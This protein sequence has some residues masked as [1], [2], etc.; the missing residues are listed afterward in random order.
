MAEL[1]ELGLRVTTNA[2]EA[3]AKLDRLDNSAEKAEQ[4]SER[5]AGSSRRT[6]G[7]M[8][9]MMANIERAVQ[10]MERHMAAAA[11]AD[12]ASERLA[13]SQDRVNASY[14][15]GYRT[16][17]TYAASFDGVIAQQTAAANS[18]NNLAAANAKVAGGGA[19]AAD[20]ID[21]VDKVNQKAAKSS[22]HMTAATLNLSRQFADIGVTAAMGM[23]PLMILI[24]QGPQ[25]ADALAVAKGQ[26]IGL[27]DMLANM[28]KV[29]GPV[30]PLL[31]GI[32]IVAGAAFGAAALAAHTLNQENKNI[33][34]GLGLSE[35]QLKRLKDAGVDTGVTIGD[36]FKGTAN[37]VGEM[38][39]PAFK[40]VKDSVSNYMSEMAANT[41]KEVKA[42]SSAFA[43]AYTYA[44]TI[45]G[46]LPAVMGDIVITTVNAILRGLEMMTNKA[47]DKINGLIRMGNAAAKGVGLNVQ[48]GTL[49]N[50]AFGQVANPNA[51]AARSAHNEA[52][53]AARAAGD[54]AAKGVDKFLDR[55]GKAIV[56]ATEARLKK[57]AGEDTGKKAREAKEKAAP[58]DRT[59]ERTAQLAAQIQGAMQEELQA[60]LAITRDIS[61]RANIERQIIEASVAQKNAQVA[62]Q[63]ADI[64]DD[65]GLSDAKKAELTK[66]LEAVQAIN[67]RVGILKTIAVNE[68]EQ[69]ALLKQANAIRTADLENQQGV[70]QSQQGLAKF[71]YERMEIE[72][73]LLDIAY[74]LEKI[75]LEEVINSTQ[76]TQAEKAIAA[77]RLRTL[78]TIT[79]NR[80]AAID[81]GAEGA[82]NRV[83]GAL[84]NAANAFQQKDWM[85]A[86]NGVMEAFGNLRAA[87]SQAGNAAGKFGAVAGVAQVAGQV[88]GGRAGGVLS[89]AASG[90]MAGFQIGGPVGGVIG[91]IIGGIGGLLGGNK[92]KKEQK[93]QEEAARQQAL[94]EAAAKRAAEARDQEIMLLELAGK[95]VEALTLRRQAELESLDA[96][97][98]ARQ[99]EIYRLMDEAEAKAKVEALNKQRREME[100]KL[101]EAAGD[102]AGALAARRADELA[103]MD[104]SLR[105]WQE[106]I[107]AVTDAREAETA[108]MERQA[109]ILD[110]INERVM[111]ANEAVD[112]AQQEVE[113]AQQRLIDAY[114]AE[115]NRIQEAIDAQQQ[116][117]DKWQDTIAGLRDYIGNLDALE[118]EIRAAGGGEGGYAASR[119]EF[120]RIAALAAS[121]DAGGQASLEGAISSFLS[122]SSSTQSRAQQARD[123]ALALRAVEDARKNA[124]EQIDKAQIQIDLAQAQIN[125]LKAQQDTLRQQVEQLVDLGG[126]VVSVEEAIHGLGGAIA[127]LAAAQAEQAAAIR[128]QTAAQQA[129]E[130][131]EAQRH[132]QL[133]AA[134]E[135][136]R[137]AAEAA[138]VAQQQQPQAPGNNP[139]GPVA[140]PTA[141][142]SLGQQVITKRPDVAAEAERLLAVADRNSPWFSQH[143][144]DRGVEG[145][146]EWWATQGAG[147]QEWQGAT[148]APPPPS[149]D[150]SLVGQVLNDLKVEMARVASASEQS[151]DANRD[152]RDT[153][154]RVT[155]GGRGMTVIE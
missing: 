50:V 36:V 68:A 76:T 48:M 97:N 9:S 114:N 127:N 59:D 55:W 107:N 58:R 22:A 14:A 19:G 101:M 29:A 139:T 4:S 7:A 73:K 10:A 123:R 132:Q 141:G 91:G 34:D 67:N 41:V 113:A 92:A 110:K 32:G 54:R 130:A 94:A 49:G 140:D 153:L 128:E 2:D 80:K 20:A 147:A 71:G 6:G 79:K 104:A 35:K 117:I 121:G 25:I 27:N 136:A 13:I 119:S 3:A 137:Q 89:G 102:A 16:T 85:G 31:T 144:L 134:Q 150:N 82:F 5:L 12:G 116:T 30:L 87:F 81:G 75:K 66:Q 152:T 60:R 105:P 77:A 143:G 70:L 142:M 115:H 122:A 42:I 120:Q 56:G 138:R 43:Y 98:R 47:I 149:N 24:Q 108:E 95:S 146:A 125:I 90:A 44:T 84:N 124:Q 135:A 83:A 51:G 155:Q 23:N 151:A 78:E 106:A 103:A 8:A 148:P 145:F 38:L 118:R 99:M 45:W 11:R 131:A 62:K 88:I 129:A 37:L 111:A 154:F 46:K 63:I 28:A 109:E 39:A 86:V 74:Q 33:V 133:L 1:A 112:R 72:L 100:I 61:E 18:A 57:A 40:K 69:D 17:T 65:K 64:A 21:K 93:R 96:A 26:G 53:A 52:D 15:A 126:K